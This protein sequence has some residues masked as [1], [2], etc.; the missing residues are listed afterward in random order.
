M[1]EDP[2]PRHSL[3]RRIIASVLLGLSVVLVGI[4]S[5]VGVAVTQSLQ[6]ALT[7]RLAV[8]YAKEH[9][10]AQEIDD[11]LSALTRA[12]V[13]LQAMSGPKGGDVRELGRLLNVMG[14]FRNLA[15]VNRRGEAVLRVDK[16]AEE[17]LEVTPWLPPS[18][19]L[20]PL[21]ATG[22]PAI[23]GG[24]GAAVPI[25]VVPEQGSEEARSWLVAAMDPQRLVRHLT[26]EHS[27]HGVYEAELL[28]QEGTVAAGFPRSGGVSVHAAL[29]AGFARSGEAGI[30]LH[31]VPG[32]V[33]DHYV[34]YVP[35]QPLQGWG[36]IIEQPRDIVVALPQR[37]WRWMMGIGF[38][39]LLAGAAVAWF[40]VRRVVTPLR[41]LASLAERFGRGDLDTPV[42][43]DR[44]DEIGL[45]G[46]TL[47]EM[48]SRLSASLKE[49]RRRGERAQTLYHLSTQL[50]TLADRDT[51]LQRI[52]SAAKELLEGDV[53]ALCLYGEPPLTVSAGLPVQHQSSAVSCTCGSSTASCPM[54]P[55]EFSGAY[56][57]TAV[58]TGSTRLGQLCV[59]R[60]AC[61]SFSEE[62]HALL[63]GLSN[64]AALAAENARLQAEV[65]S[66]S[67]LTERERIARE[68]HDGI[69]Q[70]LGIIY[71][72]ARAVEERA[73]ARSDPAS[74]ALREIASISAQA[75][76]EVRQSIFGLRTM[77]A[78]RLGLVPALTEYLHEFSEHTK[79]R[80]EL[81]V[82]DAFPRLPPEVEA[83]LIRIIQEA[84]TN[85]WRHAHAGHAWV[86][87]TVEGEQ[88]RVMVEDDGVGFDRAAV[89]SGDG[90]RFGLEAMRER[91]ESIRGALQVDSTPDQGTRVLV[92]L[93]IQGRG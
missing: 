26:A 4:A 89:T 7:E 87:F 63:S 16:A 18:A 53:A 14:V 29:V 93:P 41:R 86:R 60:R 44:D 17:E 66:L 88:L 80:V 72:Q 59:A 22:Q 40:D 46:K 57:T 25:F 38:F 71:A 21:L 54:M 20:R 55:P 51:V 13:A 10:V 39:V 8:A 85:V 32:G 75:Y 49:I 73:P 77:V 68:L 27:M 81:I 69:A 30:V 79:V 5:L 28:T 31:R 61:L 58:V 35:L 90:R 67:A 2:G 64:L 45:L 50:L 47:E 78:R 48:R 65:R 23:F 6:A 9:E 19:R 42:Q 92:T 43:E 52:V 91:A 34:A 82:P 24:G 12:S 84:L 56:L 1:E 37:L 76:E 11:A 36:V 3:Q 33:G 74:T 15:V 70:A 62:D 83:Q